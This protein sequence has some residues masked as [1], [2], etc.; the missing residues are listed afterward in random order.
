MKPRV[1]FVRESYMT[2]ERKPARNVLT[3]A[4]D[5]QKE[6]TY[7]LS[8]KVLEDLYEVLIKKYKKVKVTRGKIHPYLGMIMNFQRPGVVTVANPGYMSDLIKEYEV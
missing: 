8:I 7:N 1:K 3:V 5:Y 4:S 2:R 6:H